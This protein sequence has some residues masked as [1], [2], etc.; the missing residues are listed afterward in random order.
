[1]GK[2]TISLSPHIKGKA[3]TAGIMLDVI[4]SMLPMVAASVIIFGLRSL[5]ITAVAVIAAVLSEYLFQKLCKRDVTVNDLS[6]VVTGILLAMNMPISIPLWQVALGSVIAIVVIKQLFGGIGMNF[7]N[8]AATS[9]VI[10]LIA[11]GGT[12]SH[13]VSPDAV[14][15]TELSGTLLSDFEASATPLAATIKRTAAMPDISELF[16]GSYGGCIGETCSL[17][18]ILGGIYLMARKVITPHI[19]LV[20]VGTVFLLAFFLPPESMNRALNYIDLGFMTVSLDYAIYMTLSGGLLLGAVFM[21]TDYVTSPV[22]SWGKVIFAIGGG[23]ITFMIRRFGTL[24]EGISY[25]IL[26]MNILTPYINKWTTTKPFGAVGGK[27]N[28]K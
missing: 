8:P 26:L 14:S 16:L 23:L 20:F 13:W 17:A 1:M 5:L 4:I 9:R 24:P 2:L 19:P 11:F 15:F 28:E 12:L 22:T 6:A 7:A 18:I 25:G 3:S 10:M 27:K 21:A